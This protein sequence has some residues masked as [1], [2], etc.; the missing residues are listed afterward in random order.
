MVVFSYF[1]P[2]I[3]AMVFFYDFLVVPEV[4]VPELTSLS[5]EEAEGAFLFG[6]L[7]L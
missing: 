2:L 7:V 6:G 3:G 4:K 5:L 1:E